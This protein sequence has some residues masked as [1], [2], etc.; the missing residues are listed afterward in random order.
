M[1]KERARLELEKPAGEGLIAVLGTFMLTKV[2]HYHCPSSVDDFTPLLSSISSFSSSVQCVSR[3][4]FLSRSG[5]CCRDRLIY[6]SAYMAQHQYGQCKTKPSF[7]PRQAEILD[8][9]FESQPA[10]TEEA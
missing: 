5:F 1:E 8:Y 2:T 9:L 4:C 7:S 6:S 10:F 3:Y